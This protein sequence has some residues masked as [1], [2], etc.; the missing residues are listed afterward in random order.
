MVVTT[1]ENHMIEQFAKFKALKELLEDDL[2]VLD[3][4]L[5]GAILSNVAANHCPFKQIYMDLRVAQEKYKMRYVPAIVTEEAFNSSS[6]TYTYNDVWLQN[7]K[8]E[9]QR[10]NKEVE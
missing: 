8:K 9:F 1:E 2:G 6:S 4:E 7:V 10:V 3:A 5:D